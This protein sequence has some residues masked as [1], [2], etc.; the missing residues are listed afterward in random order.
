MDYVGGQNENVML[1]KDQSQELRHDQ[2]DALIIRDIILK[3]R[4]V[5]SAADAELPGDYVTLRQ[6]NSLIST[7]DALQ[8][9]VKQLQVQLTIARRRIP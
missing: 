7:I 1:I 2:H 5:R 6:L 4:R 9:T 8:E 3:G